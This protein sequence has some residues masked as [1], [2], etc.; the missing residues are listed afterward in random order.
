MCPC[1]PKFS[2]YQSSIAMDTGVGTSLVKF[3]LFFLPFTADADALHSLARLTGHTLLNKRVISL[4][5]YNTQGVKA[6]RWFL[7]VFKVFQLLFSIL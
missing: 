4:V 6:K 3:S 5:K 2:T 7:L 1:V